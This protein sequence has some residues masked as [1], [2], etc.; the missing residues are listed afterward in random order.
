[1]MKTIKVGLLSTTIFHIQ[2][3]NV[4]V[5]NSSNEQILKNGNNVCIPILL[6]SIFID[7][8]ISLN[9]Y[10]GAIWDSIGDKMAHEI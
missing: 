10:E 4:K 9:E 1:M 2:E 3:N 5:L 6:F 8:I 7:S